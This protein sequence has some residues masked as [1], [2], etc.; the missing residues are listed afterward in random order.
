[1][2]HSGPQ[3]PIKSSV[4]NLRR[5]GYSLSGSVLQRNDAPASWENVPTPRR[6]LLCP[7]RQATAALRSCPTPITVRDCTG[8][9]ASSGTLWWWRWELNP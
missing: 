5:R 7:T 8:L 3:P 2:S 9:L 6:Q 4:A 1:M